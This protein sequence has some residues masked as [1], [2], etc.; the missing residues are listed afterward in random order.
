MSEATEAPHSD[1]QFH[2]DTRPTLL[3]VDELECGYD[4]KTVV[5]PLSFHLHEETF[6]LIEGG[7]G[8]G[9]TTMLKTLIGLLEPVAGDYEWTIDSPALR[10]VPQTR[11]I[12][13]MLPATVYD[14]LATGLHRGGGLSSL[15]VDVDRDQLD[16]ALDQVDMEG[17]GDRLFRELSEGQKQLVLLARA[18]LG[19]PQVL[20]L[21][22]PAAAMD[23]GNEVETMELLH[24]IKRRSGLTIVMVAH[25]S[26]PARSVSNRIMTIDRDGTIEIESCLATGPT[27]ASYG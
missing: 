10:F 19:Q 25:G 3:R 4:S 2:D 24:D 27:E 12:E 6:M 1:E 13:P 22:E 17:T 11:T 16:A 8:V 26:P 14:V 7:N 5:G 23:P 20:L 21:D 15:R 18:V 9:K